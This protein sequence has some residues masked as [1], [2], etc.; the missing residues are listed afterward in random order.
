M[1]AMSLKEAAREAKADNAPVSVLKLVSE[2]VI[3]CF[4]LAAAG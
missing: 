4:N 1:L 2:Y 3:M